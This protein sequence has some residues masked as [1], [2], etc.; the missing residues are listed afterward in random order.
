MLQE[1]VVHSCAVA[2]HQKLRCR[3]LA[4]IPMILLKVVKENCDVFNCCHKVFRNLPQ[5]RPEPSGTLRARQC[6][7]EVQSALFGCMQYHSGCLTATMA[8]YVS[9]DTR[10]L[11]GGMMPICEAVKAGCF[12]CGCTLRI[13][14]SSGAVAINK[15]AS[16]AEI[17]QLATLR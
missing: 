7:R 15:T 3:S 17:R 16:I 8:L 11:L 14:N 5:N 13:P 6:D 12:H 4:T 2:H 1:L 10:E 9:R